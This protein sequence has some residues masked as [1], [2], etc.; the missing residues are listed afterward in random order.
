[1]KRFSFLFAIALFFSSCTL[2]YF[3]SDQPSGVE[4]LREV[5]QTLWGKYSGGSDSLVI[6]ADGFTTIEHKDNSVALKDT[7]SAG[8]T[9]TPAGAWKF[10]GAQA[11]LYHVREVKNDTVYYTR[12]K[13]MSYKLGPDTL[14]KSYKGNYFLSM[15]HGKV[16]LVYQ[17]STAKKGHI[18]IEVPYLDRKEHGEMKKRLEEKAADSTGFY[19][20]VT[21]F[22]LLEGEDVP[23]Y[24]VTAKP[25]QLLQ[26]MKKGLF[27]PVATFK[28]IN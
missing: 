5:P 26:L 17:V 14:L 18:A 9:R 13:V 24:V 12:R 21:P 6:R 1:M 27:K 25:E 3:T 19:S 22:R 23:A 28:K 2:V 7:L 11:Q 10:G 20:S 15:K 4:A 8:L 16:W